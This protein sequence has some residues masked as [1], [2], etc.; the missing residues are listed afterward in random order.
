MQV[1]RR[2]PDGKP[3]EYELTEEEEFA[4]DWFDRT[5]DQNHGVPFASKIALNRTLAQF[6]LT[7]TQLDPEFVDHLSDGTAERWGKRFRT[8]PGSR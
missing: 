4:K 3:R 5:L 8:K 7:P 2:G 6:K 1:I